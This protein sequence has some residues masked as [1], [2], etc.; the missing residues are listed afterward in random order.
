MINEE[1]SKSSLQYENFIM[2]LKDKIAIDEKCLKGYQNN[3]EIR[4]QLQNYIRIQ[5]EL[6]NSTN[7]N[8]K[9][10]IGNGIFVDGKYKSNQKIIIN[11]GLDV[12]VEIDNESALNI[13]KKQK[14]ILLRK[15]EL[16]KKE[17]IKNQS[18][19]KLT[20]DLSTQLSTHQTLNKEEEPKAKNI[21]SIA[22]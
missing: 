13:I 16:I 10:N 21:N 12:Y 20:K 2:S 4:E 15:S 11:I 17:I 18:Y 14:D 1:N 22:I 8:T 19:L 3:I 7:N 6:N 5:T 9:I